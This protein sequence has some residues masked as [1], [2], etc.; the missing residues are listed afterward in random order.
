MIVVSR[1]RAANA[2]CGGD[3]KAL[4]VKT[5][6]GWAWVF[7]RNTARADSLVT[8]PNKSQA[9]PRGPWGK[10]DLA[11]ARKTWADREFRLAVRLDD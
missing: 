6:D 11:W 8:T 9:L 4:Q 3:M 7:C 2:A 10:D 5:A 1:H